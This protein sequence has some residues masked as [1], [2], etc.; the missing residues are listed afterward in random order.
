MEAINDI[1]QELEISSDYL[2]SS[3]EE[4]LFNEHNGI[5]CRRPLLSTIPLSIAA[6]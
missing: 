6:F 5:Y 1:A 4:E 3:L 2:C